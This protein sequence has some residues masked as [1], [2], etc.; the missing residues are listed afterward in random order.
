MIIPQQ[1]VYRGGIVEN[2]EAELWKDGL[3]AVFGDRAPREG[4]PP[5]AWTANQDME[6]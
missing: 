6:P 2:I 4:F 1:F 3:H 5:I